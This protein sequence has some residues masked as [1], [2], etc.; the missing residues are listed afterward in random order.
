M[1]RRDYIFGG[2]STFWY[3][4]EYDLL[5]RPTNATDSVSLVCS[6]LYNRRSELAA[7]QI[8]TNLYGYAYDTIGNCHW[9]AE[10]T[11]TANNLN[12]YVSILRASQMLAHPLGSAH[13]LAAPS[14]ALRAGSLR[15]KLLRCISPNLPSEAEL[16]RCI[17]SLREISHDADGNMTSDGVFTYVYDAD[18]RF[19]SVSSNGLVLVTSQYDHKGRRVRKITQTATHTFFYDGWNL[20]Y[21][22][23]ANT[24]GTVDTF[25]YF[26]ERDRSGSLQGAGGVGGL[27]YVKHNGA[28]Y[29][30]HADAMGN[31]LRYTDAAGNVVAAYTYDAFG[32]ATISTDA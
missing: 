18:N 20:I 25:Q 31:I 12:Q 9:A 24:N 8:G 16:L 17:S 4:T 26:W 28:I 29:V 1:I 21:E 3:S 32:K 14:G 7:A 22:H 30:P 19:I 11:Y 27:L 23:I 2:Q 5:G 6:W 10:N 13:R 15:S